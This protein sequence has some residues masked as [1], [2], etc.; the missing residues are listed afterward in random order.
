MLMAALMIVS[1]WAREGG[2]KLHFAFELTRHGARAPTDS[3]EGYHVGPGMLTASGMRQRYL[4]GAYNKK[5]FTETYK[6]L[7][8]ED[9]PEEVLMMSTLVNRTMQS[10]YSELMGMFQPNRN[11]SPKL[12]PDQMRALN[13]GGVAAPPFK[14]S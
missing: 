4:L 8:L 10:G 5:R 11:K 6:L 12:T 14:V 7:D 9:G 13:L 2:D 1:T 3:N